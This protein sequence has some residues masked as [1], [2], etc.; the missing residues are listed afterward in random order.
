M[1]MRRMD[2]DDISADYRGWWRITE[3]SQWSSRFLDSLGPALLSLNGHDDR[4]QSPADQDRGERRDHRAVLV[5]GSTILVARRGGSTERQRAAATRCARAPASR[6]QRQHKQWDPAE[7]LV[8][9]LPGGVTAQG[10]IQMLLG[11]PMPREGDTYVLFV[12]GGPWSYTPFVNWFYGALREEVVQGRTVLVAANG[13]CIVSAN[14]AYLELGARVASEDQ[15]RHLDALGVNVQA[16]MSSATSQGA[17]STTGS[18][19]VQSRGSVRSER[20][21]QCAES[22]VVLEA[23]RGRARSRASASSLTGAAPAV[24]EAFHTPLPTSAF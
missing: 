21:S 19:P 9:C 20:S 16:I 13:D 10:K 4:L 18:G 2:L 14:G 8:F 12:R 22:S 17:V 15:V 11:A 3:T 6:A 5:A 1:V 24:I 23:L 7:E